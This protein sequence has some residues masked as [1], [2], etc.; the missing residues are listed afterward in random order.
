M[1]IVISFYHITNYKYEKVF[2]KITEQLRL[3]ILGTKQNMNTSD[4]RKPENNTPLKVFIDENVKQID[5]YLIRYIFSFVEVIL[6][7]KTEKQLNRLYEK[8]KNSNHTGK[9]HLTDI[10]DISFLDE[11]IETT[12]NIRPTVKIFIAY[13]GCDVHQ[14]EAKRTFLKKA[15]IFTKNN[16][17]DGTLFFVENA[18]TY[19]NLIKSSSLLEKSA[20]TIL[21]DLFCAITSSYLDLTPDNKKKEA[22]NKIR[23]LIRLQCIWMGRTSR[24]IVL[25]RKNML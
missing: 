16:Y 2:E 8:W 12:V 14:E 3:A 6:D 5:K 21:P 24:P 10:T 19:R 15:L 20:Y 18:D 23:N 25:T 17:I 22:Y 4:C 7:Q 9:F 1:V 13:C 11:I